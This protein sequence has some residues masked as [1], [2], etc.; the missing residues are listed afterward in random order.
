V[1]HIIVTENDERE[2]HELKQRLMKEFEIKK[3]GKLK[4]FLGIEVAY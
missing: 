3:L 4:Y 2:K 1:D